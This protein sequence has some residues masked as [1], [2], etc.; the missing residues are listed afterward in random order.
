MKDWEKVEQIHEILHHE[1]Y[2][3]K[4]LDVE[5]ASR[6]IDKIKEL[7]YAFDYNGIAV[8]QQIEWGWIKLTESN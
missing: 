1:T 8:K 3:H 2:S 6:F 4:F 5:E 7:S